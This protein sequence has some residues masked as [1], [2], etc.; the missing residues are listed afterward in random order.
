MYAM[1]CGPLCDS[2]AFVAII[3]IDSEWRCLLF[4]WLLNYHV[5]K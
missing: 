2:T 5:N 4:T 1:M 3:I